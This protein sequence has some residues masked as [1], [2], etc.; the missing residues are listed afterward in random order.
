MINKDGTNNIDL[1]FTLCVFIFY[2]VI[3]KTDF[4]ASMMSVLDRDLKV[5]KI[6]WST[7]LCILLI[8]HLLSFHP[9]QIY[10]RSVIF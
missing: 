5:K 3:G 10:I 1:P 6:Y 9:N 7:T 2:F 4:S 8:L